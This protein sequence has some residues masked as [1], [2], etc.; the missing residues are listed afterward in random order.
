MSRLEAGTQ[1]FRR[2]AY[3][4][5]LSFQ[6]FIGIFSYNLNIKVSAALIAE[7]GNSK[8]FPG[9][10]FRLEIV[11]N[12]FDNSA[13]TYNEEED[14]ECYKTVALPGEDKCHEEAG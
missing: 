4:V 7:E 6:G 3:Q 14:D 1:S 8:N 2:K 13:S 11:R 5:K 9:L 12:V 10:V